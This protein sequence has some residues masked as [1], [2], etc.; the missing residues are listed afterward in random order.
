MAVL[1]K[2]IP[3]VLFQLFKDSDHGRIPVKLTNC[4]CHFVQQPRITARK[5]SG[6]IPGL[7]G[8]DQVAGSAKFQILSGYLKTIIGAAQDLQFIRRI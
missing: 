2:I 8:T 1:F 4:L 5:R 7:P 3:H 6:C